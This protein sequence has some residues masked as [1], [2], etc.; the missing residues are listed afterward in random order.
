MIYSVI[1]AI[2]GPYIISMISLDTVNPIHNVP[3]ICHIHSDH[4]MLEINGRTCMFAHLK[5]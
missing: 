2:C 1:Y 5:G 3:L 4:M